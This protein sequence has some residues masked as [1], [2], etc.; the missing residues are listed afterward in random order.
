MARRSRIAILAGLVAAV[1]VLNGEAQAQ[2]RRLPG[3]SLPQPHLQSLYPVG[4]QAGTTIDVTVRGTDLEG[5]SALW[6][7]HPGLRAFHLKQATFRVACAPGT[8]IGHHDVRAVGRYGVSNPR[9]LVVGDKPAS[10]EV[11]PNNEP[12]KANPV[13]LNSVVNGEASAANDV[14]CFVIEAKKGRRLLFDLEGERIDSRIDATL[15]LLDADGREIAESR[16]EYG[17]DPFLDVTIPADGKYVVKVH[18]VVYKGSSDYPYRLSIGDGPHL[19]AI[20]PVVA[21]PGVATTFTLYGRNLGGEAAPGDLIGGKALEKKVVTITLPASG[22]PGPN[23][24]T[25]GFVRSSAAHRRGFE[26]ALTTASGRSNALFIAE[27]ADPVVVEREPNDEPALAQEVSAPCDVSAA[28]HAPGDLDLFRFRAKKG[29][30]F[31]IEAQAE[32]I[33]SQADPVF[34]VQKV[35]EKGD[36]QDLATGDDTP[37]KGDPARFPLGSV[38]AS[39]RWSAPDDGLYQVAVNDLYSS[40]RGDVRLAYRLRIRPER[41]DFALFL[42]PDSPNQPDSLTLYAGGRSLAYVLAVKSDGFNGPI[43]IEAEDLPPGVKCDPVV[44]G[45]N[46]NSAPVVFEAAEGAKPALGTARLI[47]RSR[48]GDRK[49]ELKYVHGATPLGPDV[50][51]PALGGGMVWSV[52]V[53]QAGAAALTPARLTRGFVVN[54]IGEA[55]LTLSATP[56]NR[57][58]TPGGRLAFDLAVKRRGGFAGAVAVTL[59][60]PPTGLANLPAVTIAATESA[61]TFAV[62]VPRLLASGE[63][64]LVLQGSGPFAFSK[65]PNAKTKPNVTLGEPSNAV[66]VI[67]RPAPA[68]LSVKGGAIKA[69]GTLSVEVT[70]TRKDGSAEPFTIVLDAPAALKL[71][72]EPIRAVAGQAAKLV[73]VAAPDSPVGAALGVAVR[74]TVPDRGE[75]VEI[76]E[77]LALTI[78]K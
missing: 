58:A 71:K 39:A 4:V 41:P 15:R 52:P 76:D 54:V 61:G 6:F 25:T 50:A 57:F 23:D 5:A 68:S 59:L 49:D 55:P 48:Y 74:A 27:A 20:V 26:Y 31:W 13:A 44:I 65:D 42:L 9:T 45:P 3:P 7:D 2:R 63:Y 62:T 11:E 32:A 73:V 17:A 56:R 36:P 46:Q 18:D 33:G 34:L 69:G 53:A 78:A 77:P 66:V 1:S 12:A 70:V 37:E 30:I 29:E 38:D 8:P 75:P 47:G 16:D 64:T 35:V 10:N 14:D 43:R 67:V 60:N 24:P 28:F 72:G 51:H 19:D 21:W 40:Q 22:E